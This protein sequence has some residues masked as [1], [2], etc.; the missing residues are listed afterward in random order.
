M[1][2]NKLW[3]VTFGRASLADGSIEEQK[4][5]AF[6][7]CIGIFTSEIEAKRQMTAHKDDFILELT[8]D[9][10][11][12]DEDDAETIKEI[13]DS[14]EVYGSEAEDFYELDYEV[15]DTPCQAYFSVEEK[16]IF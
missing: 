2:D 14:V 4:V 3:V 9:Y 16:E 12:D 11:P 7:R 15:C 5:D 6:C 13:I 10:N 1:T 8:E